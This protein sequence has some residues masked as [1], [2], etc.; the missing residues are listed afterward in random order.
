MGTLT[1]KDIA[2]ILDALAEKYGRGYSQ[3]KDVG[4]LQVKLSILA[5]VAQRREASAPLVRASVEV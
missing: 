5:E 4:Q 2:L 3:V 1:T